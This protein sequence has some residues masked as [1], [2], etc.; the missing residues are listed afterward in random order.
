MPRE[1]LDGRTVDTVVV[2]AGLTG[3]VAAVSLARTGQEVMVIEARTVAAGATGNTTGKVSLLQGLTLSQI[4]A[5]VGDRGVAD[6]VQ[7]NRAGQQW[8]VD[9]IGEGEFL[10][11]AT[12]IS[13][14]TSGH[15]QRHLADEFDACRAAGLPVQ[16]VGPDHVD[17]PG[18]VGV[19]AALRLDGQWQMHSVAVAHR[20]VELL[21]GL[22]ATVVEGVRVSGLDSAGSEVATVQTSQGPVRARQVI[23]ATGTPILDRG[24]HFARLEPLRSYAAAYRLPGAVPQEMSL[25][26]DAPTHSVRAVPVP[27]TGEELLLVGGYGHPVGRGPRAPQ[28]HVDALHAWTT[29][30]FP[31]AERVYR[32]SAQDY[33][34]T[35]AMPV[36]G[37]VPG[38]NSRVFAATGFNKWGLAMGA[39]AGI[40]L[41]G[42]V[43]GST[44]P[45][46]ESF[47]QVNPSL[48]AVAS[49]I[50][51]NLTAG[52]A[53]AAGWGSA[54]AAA[55][56]PHAEGQG[57]VRR[58]GVHPVGVATVEGEE[59]RVS[60]VCT[61]LGAVLR[62]NDAECSWDCPLHGSRFSAD[63]A[64]IEGPATTDLEVR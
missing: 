42:R 39:A 43:A 53:M 50:R 56:T 47:A 49:T 7:A 15:G 35:T 36:I 61:H 18:T 44:P 17:L 22:G 10:Q 59:H 23:L 26:V 58:E 11:P 46:A 54:L 45:W 24:L 21:A 14:A 6:Y 12:A 40:A 34:H 33:R 62:W 25:S 19:R 51:L 2:G 16:T 32:W 64:V 55:Q 8:W 3:L 29:R 20:L 13:Y 52:L 37:A 41:A 31:G 5:K 28:Q 4:R 63:G 27:G 48:R 9:E 38:T 30:V 60:A 1:V 57:A